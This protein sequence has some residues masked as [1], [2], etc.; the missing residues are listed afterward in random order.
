MRQLIASTDKGMQDY[1][2]S[3]LKPLWLLIQANKSKLERIEDELNMNNM[4]F[5]ME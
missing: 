5:V 4:S 2:A 3:Q 1:M